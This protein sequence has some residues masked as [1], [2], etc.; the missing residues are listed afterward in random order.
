MATH[1]KLIGFILIVL[2]L[3]HVVFPR[4]FNWKDELKSLSLINRQMMIIHTF[5][6]ALVVLLMGLLCI[7]YSTELIDTKLGKNISLGLGIFWGMRLFIQFFGYSSQ[8][9]KGKRFETMIHVL[10]S[11]LWTYISVVFFWIGVSGF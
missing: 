9:W 11:L 1:L 3:V 7:S 5:F 4:Y 10:F 6:I 8:L 2:S